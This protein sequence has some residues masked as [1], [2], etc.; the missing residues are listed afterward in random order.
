MR[1]W[2][3]IV[4]GLLMIGG[5]PNLLVGQEFKPQPFD[6]PQ[7]QGPQR[8]NRSRETGLL[9]SWPK[10]G[11]KLLWKITDAGG[12]YS[13][14]TL[15]A[16][17]LF[18]MSY[19]G[20]DEGVWARDVRTG[21]LLWSKV[22]AAANRQVDY[23][24]GSRSSPTVEDDWLYAIGVS[25]DVVCL[26]VADGKLRWR[27]H[28]I[29]DFEGVLPFYRDSYGFTESVL[30]D[31][32]HILV[33]PGGPKNTVVALDKKTGATIWTASV[34]EPRFKGQSRAAY[35]SLTVSEV[36]GV[37]QYVQVLQGTVV[38]ISSK[39]EMLWR[40]DKPSSDIANCTSPIFTKDLVFA[41]SGYGKGCGL[42]RIVS[43]KG[44]FE[45]EEIYFNKQMKNVHGGIVLVD[46]HIYGNS[47]PG[48]L[49]CLEFETG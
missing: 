34:S 45:V 40:W 41:T 35:N 23:K 26:H 20:N 47:D 17:R 6:W 5:D 2:L 16:Q 19:V 14:P 30:I 37:K 9:S 3:W 11:P 28:L 44:T 1:V 21:Q 7:W 48:Y 29:R 25:G 22:V 4:I 43:R 27:R 36:A 42:A 8:D 49:M 46:G 24:E 38:G 39:G 31:G 33:T 13:S 18:A 12:G 32:D 15:A 10:E